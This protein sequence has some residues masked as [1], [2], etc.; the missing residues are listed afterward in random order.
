MSTITAGS[1]FNREQLDKEIDRIKSDTTLSLTDPSDSLSELEQLRDD[2]I[3]VQQ[4]VEKGLAAPIDADDAAHR[5]ALLKLSGDVIANINAELGG[6]SAPPT[7]APTADPELRGAGQVTAPRV[8]DQGYG[9]DAAVQQSSVQ[10]DPSN[11]TEAYKVIKTKEDIAS[12]MNHNAVEPDIEND[13]ELINA[14][15]E[16]VNSMNDRI[17]DTYEDQKELDIQTGENTPPIKIK[18]LGYCKSPQV[19]A[20]KAQED[21]TGITGALPPTDNIPGYAESYMKH[22]TANPKRFG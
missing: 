18:V 1:L 7:M 19:K 13:K 20:A 11:L 14:Y 2:A 22:S 15:Y 17:E 9:A 4:K 12:G 21:A 16:L 6:Q 5:L 8:K 10:I 3:S